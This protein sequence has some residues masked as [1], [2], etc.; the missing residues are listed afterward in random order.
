MRI[1]QKKY[2]YI[3]QI[4]ERFLDAVF[5]ILYPLSFTHL[6][7]ESAIELKEIN[8]KSVFR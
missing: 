1:G 8:A 2:V 7:I 6:F 3:Y 4:Y 5:N